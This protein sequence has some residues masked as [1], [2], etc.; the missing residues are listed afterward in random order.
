MAEPRRDFEAEVRSAWPALVR[1]ASVLCWSSA[2]A[3]DVV[4]ET[5][6]RAMKARGGFR[7]DSSFLTW[8][9]VILTRVATAAN[10]RRAR[11]VPA[12]AR[13]LSPEPLPPVDAALIE[14]EMARRM[15]DAIR[16]LPQR[17]REMVTLHYLDERPYRDIAEALGVSI[18]TVKATLF[19]AKQSLREALAEKEH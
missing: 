14:D 1:S 6:L 3:E 8:I 7:G 16:Q 18:G 2:D 17:Q 11:K 19:N 5:V 9:Y 13:P 15:I 4:Q 12:G 10:Q